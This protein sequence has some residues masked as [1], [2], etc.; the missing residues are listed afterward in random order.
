MFFKVKF[1]FLNWLIPFYFYFDIKETLS[2]LGGGS[3]LMEP[4]SFVAPKRFK[5]VIDEIGVIPKTVRVI[6]AKNKLMHVIGLCQVRLDS[7]IYATKEFRK[8]YQL[9]HYVSCDK[10]VPLFT[11]TGQMI[12]ELPILDIGEGYPGIGG[13]FGGSSLGGSLHGGIQSESMIP[14]EEQSSSGPRS[15]GSFTGYPSASMPDILEGASAQYDWKPL[16]RALSSE[17]DES[18]FSSSMTPSSMGYKNY[19]F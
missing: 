17:W 3:Q 4:C 7:G 10:V 5:V 16:N 12:I 13:K 8:V 19:G 1:I 6:M 2:A 9:P 15:T 14:R 18:K 11:E